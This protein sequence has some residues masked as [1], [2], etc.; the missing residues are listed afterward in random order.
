MSHLSLLTSG[1]VTASPTQREDL[2]LDKGLHESPWK[3]GGLTL[4]HVPPA[5]DGAAVVIGEGLV[6]VWQTDGLD[7]RASFGAAAV[8][9][10]QFDQNWT[11]ETH[12]EG[13]TSG[14]LW[15]SVC[16]GACVCLSARLSVC[17]CCCCLC[18][19]ATQLL[20]DSVAH[21]CAHRATPQVALWVNRRSP[22]FT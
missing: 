2:L 7:E 16:V 1:R 22:Q 10:L 13:G 20:S 19:G 11:T 6:F 18:R 15:D 21:S 3:Q 17:M 8:L 9:L 12:C 14:A 5:A 4:V